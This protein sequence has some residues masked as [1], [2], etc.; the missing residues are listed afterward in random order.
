M[1]RLTRDPELKYTSGGKAFTRISVAVKRPY[2]ADKTDFIDITFWEKKAETVA[3]YFRKGH[4]ILVQGFITT[5]T[6]D[7]KKYVSVT[8]TEFEFIETKES[9]SSM[10]HSEHSETASKS[11]KSTAGKNK[12]FGAANDYENDAEDEMDEENDFPF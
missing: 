12:A 8:G 9:A 10:G 2:A 7:E 5:N 6:K 4:R 11:L 1:G 3:E